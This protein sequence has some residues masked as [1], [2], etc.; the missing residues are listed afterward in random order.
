MRIISMKKLWVNAVPY[1]KEVVISALESGAEAVILPD[2]QTKTVRE[3]GKIKTV[4]KN[5]DI[6]PGV[7]VDFID[8]TGKADEEKAAA[9]AKAPAAAKDVPVAFR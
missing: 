6:V 3:F 4:E 8:I 7:D 5:G 2:G 9:G 1:K